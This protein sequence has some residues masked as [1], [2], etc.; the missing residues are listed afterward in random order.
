VFESVLSTETDNILKNLKPEDLP[1]GSYLAGGTAVALHLGH[2]RSAD[3]DFFTPI[4]FI[5]R[6]WQEKLERD[7]GFK[8]I[9]RDWQT[10][11]GS[12]NDVKISI[13]GYFYPQIGPCERYY[14]IPVASLYDLAAMKLDVIIGRGTKRDFIDVYFLARKFTLTTLFSY[15]QQKYNHFEEKELMLKK[16]LVYFADAEKDDMPHMLAPVNWSEIKK[17]FTKEIRTLKPG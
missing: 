12:V 13:F 14:H 2:R 8:L 6:Q 15:Y 9:K 1:E 3:L 17:W 4:E 16:S 7:L 11:I 5:E 10:L